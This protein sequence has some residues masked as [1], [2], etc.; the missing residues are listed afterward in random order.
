MVDGQ[1]AAVPYAGLSPGAAGLYQIN[2]QVPAT[3]RSG[4]LPVIVTQ[5]GVASNANT[6]SVSQ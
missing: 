2:F 1:M 5:N 4:D 3:A 6:L